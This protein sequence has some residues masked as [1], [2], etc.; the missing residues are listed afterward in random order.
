MCHQAGSHSCLLSTQQ[1]KDSNDQGH[2]SDDHEDIAGVMTATK[3]AHSIQS[4]EHIGGVEPCHQKHQAED[5]EDT[6]RETIHHTTSLALASLLPCA[7]ALPR[8]SGGARRTPT[9]IEAY[10]STPSV[11]HAQLAISRRPTGSAARSRRRCRARCRGSRA[12][13]C[14]RRAE[15]IAAPAPRESARGTRPG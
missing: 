14:A 5:R 1:A 15:S 8:V 11:Y 6:A 12:I 10:H 2:R 9:S 3:A 4:P 7:P 13:C